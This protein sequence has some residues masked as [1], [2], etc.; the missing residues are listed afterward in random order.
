MAK[1]RAY[2]IILLLAA[3][4]VSAQ[5]GRSRLYKP[6]NP[7]VHFVGTA[8]GLDILENDDFRGLQGK[9]V[10]VVTNQTGT[11][12]KGIHILDL[13]AKEPRIKMKAIFG[14]EHGVYGDL[15]D[16][17]TV[18][19]SDDPD[20]GV[21]IYS[22]YGQTR[23]PTP[24]MLAG[25]D[26]V[27]F[28][29]QD[30]GARYYTYASTLTLVMD[31]AARDNI[32]I[33]VLDRPNP[34]RGDI[35]AGPILDKEYSSFVGMHPI[36]IRHGL[37]LGELAIMINEERWLTNRRRA[38]LTVVPMHN[39]TRYMGWEDT[40]LT[41][42]P[43]S[44]NIPVPETALAYL[45]TCLIE[46]TNVSEG[47]GTME[48]FTTLGAPWIEE[49]SFAAQ[50]NRLELPGVMFA[51]MQFTPR[52]IEG[53]AVNPKFEGQVCGGVRF[54]IIDPLAF[55]PID[56][57]VSILHVI[58]ETYPHKFRFLG[59]HYIDKL[60]GSGFI[61]DYIDAGRDPGKVFT[62]YRDDSSTFYQQREQYLIYKE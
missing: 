6:R 2:L 20:S 38:K 16:G 7:T 5:W 52:T 36:P 60:W 31:A 47:R 11:N 53:M 32:H 24:D 37:T 30:V 35:I 8:T 45:G 41:W 22:L 23:K 56:A 39:W 9:N 18:G 25:V 61:R 27:I 28:D 54:E 34:V 14:P 59:S 19:D 42:I 17:E 62:Y 48:P 50:L 21:R 46:G 13:L 49:K 26:V 1:Y 55:K 3:T 57:M 58:R 43:P 10:A 12:R 29:M 33:W 4:S 44:P 15:A 40:R 51:P